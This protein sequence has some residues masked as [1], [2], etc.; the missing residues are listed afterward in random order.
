M[1]LLCLES[2]GYNA[3][4]VNALVNIKHKSSWSSFPSIL[5]TVEDLVAINLAVV[6]SALCIHVQ[7]DTQLAVPANLSSL[8]PRTRLQSGTGTCEADSSRRVV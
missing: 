7:E 8:G 5:S 3:P 6:R 2:Y 1:Y 4:S